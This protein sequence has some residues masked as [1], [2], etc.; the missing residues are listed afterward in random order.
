MDSTRLNIADDFPAVTREDW[1]TLVQKSLRGAPFEKKLVTRLYEGVDVQP[2]YTASDWPGDDDPSGLPGFAP[3]ARGASAMGPAVGGWDVRQEHASPSPAANNAA[4]R[5]DLER[6]ASSVLITVRHA[7]LRPADAGVV[8]G[9]MRDLGTVLAGVQLDTHAVHIVAD[10]EF[11]PAAAML[12]CVWR[13]RDVEPSKARG[14]F[15][16]DPLGTLARN[17]QLPW[18]ADRALL[19]LSDLAV[20][21]SRTF[22]SVRSLQV[23]TSP[24]HNAG[25][26]AVHEIAI[27]AATALE[28]LRAMAGCGLDPAPAS[29]QMMF[30]FSVGCDLFLE[31]AKIR[32]VRIVWGSVLQRCDAGSE[33]RAT[34][35]HARTSRRSM[36]ARDPWVNLLRAMTG[37]VAAAVAG[38]DA[39][40]VAPFDEVLGLPDDFSR[41]VARNTQAML[42]DEAHLHRI[43]DPAGGSWYVESL[44]DRLARAA[45]DLL[46]EIERRGGM[47]AALLDGTVAGWIGEA[48][49]ARKRNVATRKDAITGVSEFPN[50]GEEKLR[51]ALPHDS[52]TRAPHASETPPAAAAALA[53]CSGIAREQAWEAGTLTSEVLAAARAGASL[54][55]L[56]RAL[57]GP[58]PLVL[59]A[60]LAPMRLSEPF[61]ELRDASEACLAQDGARPRMFLASLG[62]VAQYGARSTWA[63]NFFEAGGFEVIEETGVRTA[64]AAAAAFASCGARIVT[65][66]SSDEVYE[67]I[68]LDVARALKGAG[69]Q[70]V[71]LAGRPG[72]RE[73]AYR[74]AG[75]DSFIFVG[76]DVLATLRQLMKAQGVEIR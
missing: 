61:E 26:T 30:T 49:A 46:Q 15:G 32:A 23:D 73:A 55:A 69:A 22:P 31:I 29:R 6:G 21:T 40:T 60:P 19:M 18:P 47:A 27:A 54:T 68:A 10:A 13:D 34:Q 11:L 14:G 76:C 44:T 28:Y 3:Y 7:D 59:T 57:A 12:A 33:M 51:R 75:V 38:A 39:I 17:G 53:R 45:W 41:R 62:S 36:A 64:E 48:A 24:Y 4:I 50:G 2:L 25:A 63:S 52:I 42:K 72:N 71:V 37:V 9:N 74:E 66:C 67:R 70:T 35:I 65:I 1:M 58:A 56:A 20:W 43:I 16:C 8:I 5:K